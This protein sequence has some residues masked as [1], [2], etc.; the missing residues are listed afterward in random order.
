MSP[1]PLPP[2]AS[3]R[4]PLTMGLATLCILIG[5]FGAWATQTQ[6][7]GAVLA[8]GRVVVEQ[9]RQV[10]QHPD[11]GVVAELAVAEGDRVRAGDVLVRLEAGDLACATHRRRRHALRAD[12]PAR[13]ARGAARRACRHPV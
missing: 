8:T 13:A 5:G 11:G 10:V 2:A 12:G 3:V 9:N 4:G 1:A 6:I 7:A